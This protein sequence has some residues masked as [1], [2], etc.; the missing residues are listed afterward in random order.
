VSLEPVRLGASRGLPR[1]GQVGSIRPDC[2]SEKKCQQM[3][4]DIHSPVPSIVSGGRKVDRTAGR[5][6]S[7]A[8]A[9][10]KLLRPV[11]FRHPG[12]LNGVFTPFL[13]AIDSASGRYVRA[14]ATTAGTKCQL[15]QSPGTRERPTRRRQVYDRTEYGSLSVM[16]RI[17]ANKLW[18]KRFH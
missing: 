10:V 18:H 8:G 4:G 15:R 6:V 3:T 1:T 5:A 16:R 2:A 7:P 9:L 11:C 17:F 13:D 12:R 14:A